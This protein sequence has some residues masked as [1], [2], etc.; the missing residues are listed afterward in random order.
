MTSIVAAPEM[1]QKLGEQVKTY[2]DTFAEWIEVTDKVG[3][4]VAVIDYN[5]RNML[6][7]ADEIATL[8]KIAHAAPCG[9]R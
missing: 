8:G 1:K 5:A 4:P 7:V 6:P 2:V 9:P 3:P